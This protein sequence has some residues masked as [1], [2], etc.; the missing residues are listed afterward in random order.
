MPVRQL[1]NVSKKPE[2]LPT[3]NCSGEN[4]RA[5]CGDTV[6]LEEAVTKI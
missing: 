2:Q 6:R 3:W 5:V 4:N 1:D